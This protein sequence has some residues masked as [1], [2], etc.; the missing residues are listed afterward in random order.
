MNQLPPPENNGQISD[1][2]SSLDGTSFNTNDEGYE[3]SIT[4]TMLES[5]NEY[6]TSSR[7]AQVNPLLQPLSDT[8]IPSSQIQSRLPS[9]GSISYTLATPVRPLNRARN[10]RSWTWGHFKKVYSDEAISSGRAVSTTDDHFIAVCQEKDNLGRRCDFKKDSEKLRGG[11]TGVLK[12]HLISSHSFTRDGQKVVPSDTSATFLGP[13]SPEKKADLMD[14]LVECF[15]DADLP[16]IL[17]ESKYFRLLLKDCLKNPCDIIRSGSLAART[18]SKYQDILSKIKNKLEKSCKPIAFILDMWTSPNGYGILAINGTWLDENFKLN[19]ELLYFNKI[20]GEH[21]GANLANII[22]QVLKD[23]NLC[24]M[25][26]SIS[27]GNATNNNTLCKHLE[28]SLSAWAC[29]NNATVKFSI[30]NRVSCILML[31]I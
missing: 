3:S 11:T 15:A 23:F 14:N 22:F 13:L 25:L 20:S 26:F 24:E 16:F 19:R 7:S 12:S 2:V 27:A 21:N 8:R 10:L 28:N 4:D 5:I 29:T 17:I 6:G 18:V 30:K 31:S 1:D 9:I